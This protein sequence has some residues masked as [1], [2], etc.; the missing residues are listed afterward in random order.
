M[1]DLIVSEKKKIVRD[2]KI[3]HM[4]FRFQKLCKT[5]NVN[6]GQNKTWDDAHA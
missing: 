5:Q 4:S 1:C 2:K 6:T 3:Q